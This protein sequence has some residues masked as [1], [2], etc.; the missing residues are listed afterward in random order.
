MQKWFVINCGK[1]CLCD[2]CLWLIS[3]DYD[4]SQIRPKLI[5]HKS[6]TTQGLNAENVQLFKTVKSPLAL[7]REA[8]FLRGR[9]VTVGSDDIYK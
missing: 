4:Q 1:G 9:E 2:G 7:R 6:V 8:I 3:K 5:T